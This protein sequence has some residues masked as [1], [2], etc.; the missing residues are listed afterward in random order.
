MGNIRDKVVAALRALTTR[1]IRF[2]Y[3][4]IPISLRNASSRRIL[5]W[6]AVEASIAAKR[7]E[8]WGLPTYLQI[9]PSTLCNL[10]CN[11]CPVSHRSDEPVGHLDP[12][13]AE[14]F[15]DELGPTALLAVLWGWGEPFLAPGIYHMIRYARSRGLRTIS[16][17]NGHLFTKDDHA[18][19]LVESG[20]DALIVSTSGISPESYLK[21]RAA[22]FEMPLRGLRNIVAWRRKLNTPL[23]FLCLTLIITSDNEH[24]VDQT[25]ELAQELGIEMLNL[26]KL[27]PTT[28]ATDSAI[29]ADPELRRFAY[30]ADGVP[31]RRTE[32]SCKA[33][34]HKTTLRW[35]GRINS[36][37]FDSCGESLLGDFASGSAKEIWRGAAYR[38]LRRKFRTSWGEI[39]A[40]AR[41]GHGFQGG[42]YGEILVD[43]VRFGGDS[44]PPACGAGKSPGWCLADPPQR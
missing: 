27:N 44:K 15:I 26:K 30:G 9:E 32:N 25:R 24:E 38:D 12:R 5:N 16:S 23:P 10:A 19:Q 2:E 34:F 28:T 35:D 29:P 18:R 41:C 20:L 40:C 17:T 43:T 31:V 7:V 1:E 37:T 3:E 42:D 13:L 36:C 4:R 14:R 33:M 22:S 6:I 8:P 39:P 11:Y 21:S